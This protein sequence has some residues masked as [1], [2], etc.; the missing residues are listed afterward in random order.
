VLTAGRIQLEVTFGGGA[1]FGIVKV[2][3]RSNGGG[4][5]LLS[6][7][8][9]TSGTS[10]NATPSAEPHKFLI[11]TVLN[12]PITSGS[13]DSFQTLLGLVAPSET[14]TFTLSYD[15]GTTVR[16]QTVTVQARR[17]TQYGSVLEQLFGVP[18]GGASDGSLTINSN[19][20]GEVYAELRSVS[21]GPSRISVSQTL[22]IIRDDSDFVTGAES[23]RPLYLEGIEQSV[24]P[25]RGS[26]WAL[27]LNEISGEA[28]TVVVSIYE[29]GNR[30][31]PIVRKEFSIPA[32][33]R[34]RLDNLFAA[35]DLANVN[36]LKD[37]TNMLLSVV[38]KSGHGAATAMAFFIDNRTGDSKSYILSPVAGSIP[39]IHLATVVAPPATGRRRAVRH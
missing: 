38:Y 30:T 13:S 37:R 6:R 23:Q 8:A 14:S 3:D 10:A 36:R 16:T 20:G 4:S 39:N 28:T 33:A 12:G 11:P 15:D 29:S 1:A 22:P 27:L 24:D 19:S 26:R 5:T 2:L 35:L 21:S 32:F 9:Q 17:T 25:T 31:A 34:S 18:V 7:P